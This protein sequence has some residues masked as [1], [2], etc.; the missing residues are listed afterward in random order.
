MGVRV[1]QGAARL[2]R[3]TGTAPPPEWVAVAVFADVHHLDLA[4]D[5][6][7]SWYI[8][9]SSHRVRA[10]VQHLEDTARLPSPGGRGSPPRRA[11][12]T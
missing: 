2:L 6:H 12:K 7:A 5:G 3:V 8:D 1:G 4:A 10:L 9:G 11:P